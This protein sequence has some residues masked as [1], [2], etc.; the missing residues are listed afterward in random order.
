[1]DLMVW[2]WTGSTPDLVEVLQRINR[3]SLCSAG[4]V[5][6]YL[7]SVYCC[8]SQSLLC[9]LN[10][11]DFLLSLWCVF[12]GTCW[13]L[14]SWGQGN[15]QS[16]A[17]ADRCSVCWK[18]NHRCWIW[19]CWDCQVLHIVLEILIYWVC[20]CFWLKS[21]SVACLHQYCIWI[22]RHLD[23]INVMTYDFH[24]AWERFTGHNSPLYRGSHDSGDLIHFNT[25][26]DVVLLWSSVYWK[27]K[28]L[29][30]NDTGIHT[31]SWCNCIGQF[32]MMRSTTQLQLQL[33]SEVLQ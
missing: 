18:G 11:V 33:T 29:W 5:Q 21:G 4:W 13:S 10:F 30:Y 26:R 19:D 27:T 3:G 8:N 16:S 20:P 6:I 9:G 7:A 2:T 24:G 17:H 14:C 31:S 22:F 25:V 32:T 15:R 1:M 23:F 12:T 28:L